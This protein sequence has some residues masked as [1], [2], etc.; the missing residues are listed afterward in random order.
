M[1]AQVT[2]VTKNCFITKWQLF[3]TQNQGSNLIPM[4]NLRIDV[5]TGLDA[6]R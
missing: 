5:H 1:T 4:H 6:K 2:E 3:D